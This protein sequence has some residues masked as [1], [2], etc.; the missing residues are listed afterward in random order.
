M[1]AFRAVL[2]A[3]G[4]LLGGCA[5]TGSAFGDGAGGGEPTPG[6]EKIC[7]PAA[8]GRRLPAGTVADAKRG[9]E[10]FRGKDAA[11]IRTAAGRDGVTEQE[12]GAAIYHLALAEL[13]AKHDAEGV[14]LLHLAADELHEPLSLTKLSQ[15]YYHGG[16]KLEFAGGLP[17]ADLAKSNL[18]IGEAFAIVGLVEQKTGDKFLLDRVVSNGLGVVDGLH[19]LAVAGKFDEAAEQKRAAPLIEAKAAAYKARYLK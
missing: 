19:T 5:A 14:A 10:A 15:F 11:A 18:Y 16:E 13:K 8:K 12:F 9:H 4:F 1:A 7:G 2:M 3:G 6:V 17:K